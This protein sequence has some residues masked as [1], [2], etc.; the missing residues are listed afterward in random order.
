V[1]RRLFNLA[2]AVSLALFLAT[3]LLW[4]RS[5]VRVDIVGDCRMPAAGANWYRR[6]RTAFSA[7]GGVL[8][9]WRGVLVTTPR[10]FDTFT[11]RPGE[12]FHHV[13]RPGANMPR[14]R[15]PGNHWFEYWWRPKQPPSGSYASPAVLHIDTLRV[16]VPYWFPAL[17]T[18]AAP[19]A[20]ITRRRRAAR[21]RAIG[22]C[23]TCGY[24][25]RATPRKC[26]EC[27]TDLPPSNP[28]TDD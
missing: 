6:D 11:P 5:Y 22:R 7:D 1:R 18:A 8:Y 19:A 3:L 10:Y 16:R 12:R 2:A 24:D 4:A 26:P 27:G 13:H 15:F 17:V 25:C 9:L 21:R 28:A 23:P 20:W 14:E